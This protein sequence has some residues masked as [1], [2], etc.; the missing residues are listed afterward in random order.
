VISGYHVWY[1]LDC[2]GSNKKSLSAI[3]Y[4]AIVILYNVAYIA[5][6]SLTTWKY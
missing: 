3:F 1:P 2:Y 5:Q 4:F 6:Y